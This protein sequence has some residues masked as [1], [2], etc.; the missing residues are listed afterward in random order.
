MNPIRNLWTPKRGPD[1]PTPNEQGT[2]TNTAVTWQAAAQ[3][4]CYPDERLYARLDTVAAAVHALPAGTVRA[5]LA[6]TVD[7]L[8]RAEVLEAQAHYVDTFDLRRRRALHLT[9][10]TD[11]DT[12]RRGHA[13]ARIQ[14]CYTAAGWRVASGE[15]PDHLGV[16]LEFSARGDARR[17]QELL[18][19]FR[20]GLELLHTELQQYGTPYAGVLAVVLA[21]LPSASQRQREDARRIAEEGPPVEDVGLE[22]YGGP[23]ALGMPTV[24]VPDDSAGGE[25]R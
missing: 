2:D 7:Y 3:L 12:R 21:T 8:R 9:Y 20:P 6:G 19:E 16:L 10:Y 22:P 4:L 23:V 15:L 18:V 14:E 11:G 24:G 17:G 5:G 13:L 1:A 25:Q